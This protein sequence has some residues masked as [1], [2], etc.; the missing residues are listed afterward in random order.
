[1]H[2]RLVLLAPLALLWA[3]NGSAIVGDPPGDDDDAA[4]D[5]DDAGTSCAEAAVSFD[6]SEGREG[7]THESP[8][9]GFQD[10]WEFGVPAEREC[11]SGDRCWATNP[12]GDYG[13]C[14]SGRLVSPVIDL[15]SCAGSEGE[16][17]L[18]FQHI[19]VFESP[20]GEGRYW[21]GGLVQL[22]TDDD[23][24]DVE[25]N[26]GYDGELDGNLSECDGNFEANGREAWSGEPDREV[27]SEVRIELDEEFFV[28]DL[29]IGF[30]FGSDRAAV[31]EGWT[32]DSVALTVD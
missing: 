31:A 15:S 20:S 32:I 9:S 16:V 5:D 4:V 6:F 12:Q 24:F 29:Q 14:N 17:Q 28:E 25:P 18:T 7:F 27:W 1:M 10:P 23:W 26:G 2:H 19:Y 21:D 8:D 13:N 3:C 30:L 11:P 22:R